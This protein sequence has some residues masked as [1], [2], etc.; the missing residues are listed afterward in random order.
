MIP[1]QPVLKTEN[2]S[3][4]VSLIKGYIVAQCIGLTVFV[5]T[6]GT[7][8]CGATTR[9]QLNKKSKFLTSKSKNLKAYG[10]E[11]MEKNESNNQ[12]HINPV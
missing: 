7:F 3:F 6:V 5:F 12:G 1:L 8:T 2:T 4:I 10:F 9:G 11:R